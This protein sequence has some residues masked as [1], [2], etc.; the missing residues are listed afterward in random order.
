MKDIDYSK[1][2]PGCVNIVRY[3]NSVGLTTSM[4]CEGHYTL[5]QSV[6]WVEF[7]K[8][9]TD[10]DIFNF[11]NNHLHYWVSFSGKIFKCFIP[12]GEFCKRALPIKDGIKYRW[13]YI[14]GNSKA[15]DQD[16]FIWKK[17]DKGEILWNGPSYV[18]LIDHERYLNCRAINTP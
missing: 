10:E 16:V 14:V 13:R 17:M 7:S 15:A 9:L 3:F 6:F 8:E 12:N 4:C 1:L 2:D 11:M 5:N 18:R